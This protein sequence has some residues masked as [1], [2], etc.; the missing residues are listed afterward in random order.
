MIQILPMQKRQPLLVLRPPLVE[1]GRQ[2]PISSE[3]FNFFNSGLC[4]CLLGIGS[5][6]KH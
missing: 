5:E 1:R 2:C 6:V 4:M 3:L